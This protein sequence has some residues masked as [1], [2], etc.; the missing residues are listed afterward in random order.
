M[1]SILEDLGDAKS[2]KEHDV[3]VISLGCF[4]GHFCSDTI[5]NHMIKVLPDTE[6]KEILKGLDFTQIQRKIKIGLLSLHE[7]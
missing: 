6:I 3:N 4:R 1:L 5:F 2:V 7:S